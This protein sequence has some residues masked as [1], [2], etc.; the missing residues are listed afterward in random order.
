MGKNFYNL[1]ETEFKETI[2]KLKSLPKVDAP[3]NF[4]YNLMVKIN[5]K[6]FE[7]KT[8]KKKISFL[9]KILPA[10][11]VVAAAVLAFFLIPEQTIENS[12]L[13]QFSPLQ[14]IDSAKQAELTSQSA[15]V[16]FGSDK[17]KSSF[18]ETNTNTEQ[19]NTVNNKI[20]VQ[21]NDVVVKEKTAIPFD[22]SKQVD[23]DKFINGKAVN[24]SPASPANL[25]SGG[26]KPSNFEG[27]IVK[28]KDER[29][30][31]LKNK[32]K[33]DSL[34]AKSNKKGVK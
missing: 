17:N 19:K 7:L 11:A 18:E 20:K 8:E 28:N 14:V 1:E 27:F 25:V 22:P 31:L 32:S 34:S 13:L 26:E 6:N 16:D 12:S 21:P 33:E 24:S 5:N 4:E 23:I 29:D 10:P 9:W 3:D 15:V 2:D 30:S